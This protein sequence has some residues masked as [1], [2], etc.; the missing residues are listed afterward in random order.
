MSNSNNKKQVSN[1]Q[2]HH[3]NIKQSKK[4]IYNAKMQKSK[5]M[6][7]QT[8][9]HNAYQKWTENANVLTSQKNAELI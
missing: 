4:Y 7:K 2:N 6:N 8:I 1:V 9:M 3:E 5:Q